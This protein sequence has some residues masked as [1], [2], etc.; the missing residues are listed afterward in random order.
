MNLAVPCACNSRYTRSLRQR[1]A[2]FTLIELLVVIAIIS[3][4]IGLLLPAVQSARE[5]AR[6]IQCSNNL[7]NLSLALLNYESANRAFPAM[8]G[9][10]EGFSSPAAGNHLRLSAFVGLLPFLELSA[11]YNEIVMPRQSPMPIAAGGPFPGETFG[12]TFTPWL[13]QPS[14]LKCPTEQYEK[15]ILDP[16]VTNYGLSVGD[17]VIDV[18]NGQTRGFFQANTWRRISDVLDGTSNSLALIEMRIEQPIDWFTEEELSTP[19]RV[20]SLIIVEP[21]Y[22]AKRPL[23]PPPH[24]G[25]GYRWHDGAPVYTAVNNMLPPNDTSATNRISHDLVN[26]QFAAGSYHPSLILVAFVDGGVR[27]IFANVD[28]GNSLHYAPSGDSREPSPYGVWGQLSTISCGEV[29]ANRPD[30]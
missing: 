21:K 24:Y 1:P 18:A 7:K 12:G 27:T 20:S 11:L 26:G 28:I 15:G 25:R 13:F 19:A 16:G 6:R 17:N 30:E 5:S 4:M 14:L 22:I 8:R 3:I 10:T 29:T 9:G 23:P 2:G